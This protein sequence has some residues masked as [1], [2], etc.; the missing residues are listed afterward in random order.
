MVDEDFAPGTGGGMA[1]FELSTFKEDRLR[2]LEATA[3]VR[4]ALCAWAFDGR[5]VDGATA[6]RIHR[7]AMHP[8]LPEK[9]MTPRLG[10][11]C[12]RHRRPQSPAHGRTVRARNGKAR[13]DVGVTLRVMVKTLREARSPTIVEL[14]ELLACL[15]TLRQRR[16]RGRGVGKE[17][18]PS[19]S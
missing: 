11:S 13:P 2:A 6:A 19:R 8:E 17:L 9:S 12:S 5:V 16:C 15:R 10:R 18:L 14:A 3:T 7:K 1:S 4:C